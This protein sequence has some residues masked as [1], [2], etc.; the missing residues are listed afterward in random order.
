MLMASRIRKGNRKCSG[1]IFGAVAAFTIVFCGVALFTLFVNESIAI[2]YHKK[3]QH[4]ASIAAQASSLY[5]S[6]SWYSPNISAVQQVVLDSLNLM[7]LPSSGTKFDLSSY[8]GT[9]SPPY[10]CTVSSP[11]PVI[12][13]SDWLKFGQWTAT[14]TSMAPYNSQVGYL[15]VPY[16]D[17]DAPMPQGVPPNGAPP[18]P[19]CQECDIASSTNLKQI[20]LPIVKAPPVG[21]G[22]PTGSW[23]LQGTT[24]PGT[25]KSY[26]VH[27]AVPACGYALIPPKSLSVSKLISP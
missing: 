7:G 10:T 20:C 11:V 14:G 24:Y 17:V 4:A 1:Q 22:V 25:E 6:G 5:C 3:M 13:D 16:D 23:F 21:T 26:Q 2:Y 18:Y 9:V 8:I 27:A 19:A 12:G 15:I